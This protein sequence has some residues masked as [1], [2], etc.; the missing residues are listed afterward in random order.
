MTRDSLL[1]RVHRHLEEKG[2]D[3][4]LIGA[5]ALAIHGVSRSTFDQDFLVFD[6][7]VLA[8]AMWSGL[9]DNP[10]VDIRHGDEQDPLAGVVRVSSDWQRDVDVIVG[11]H[12]WQR[13]IIDRAAEFETPAGLMRVAS[14][15]D[16]VLLKLYAGGQQDLW[17][18]E[19]LRAVFGEALDLA[20][21]R[22]IEPLP[23]SA[24]E[25]WRRLRSSDAPDK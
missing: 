23:S 17:D 18:V 16:L 12:V 8:S 10:R 6:R 14:V 2:I 3:H 5:A 9:A 21:D 22:A 19:Q 20:V 25:M 24:R 7:Q 13:Q 15:E 1:G 11:R 4:A